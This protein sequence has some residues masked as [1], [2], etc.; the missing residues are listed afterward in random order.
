MRQPC[1]CAL[2]SH[3][4]DAPRPPLPGCVCHAFERRLR[5]D[6]AVKNPSLLARFA[7]VRLLNFNRSSAPVRYVSRRSRVGRAGTISE[8]TRR[9]ALRTAL[10]AG[11]F[12]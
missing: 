9:A 11:L 3:R 7:R 1:A 4:P 12:E 2:T 6:A 8:P 5:L 10:T